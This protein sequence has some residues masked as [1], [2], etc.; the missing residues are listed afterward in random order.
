MTS[1]VELD[2]DHPLKEVTPP[3][4]TQPE[5]FRGSTHDF[6]FESVASITTHIAG[7]QLFVDY[8]QQVKG[9]HNINQGLAPGELAIHQQYKLIKNMEIR[10]SS[11]FTTNQNDSNMEMEVTAE[12]SLYAC[13]VIPDRGDMLVF[14][15]GDG[16][17]CVCEIT[18]S[19]RM[20]IFKETTYKI[21]YQLKSMLDQLS[22]RNLNLKVV[23]TY[24]FDRNFLTNG[25]NPVIQEDDFAILRNIEQFIQ[26][27]GRLYYAQFFSHEFMTLV[28]PSQGTPVYD[29]FLMRFIQYI[30]DTDSAPENRYTR[31]FNIDGD[32]HFST[33]T[34]WDV[35]IEQDKNLLPFISTKY[36]LASARSFARDPQFCSLYHSGMKR[37]VYPGDPRSRYTHMTTVPQKLDIG[38]SIVHAPANM[39]CAGVSTM[40]DPDYDQLIGLDMPA[41]YEA[42]KEGKWDHD[43][44][45]IIDDAREFDFDQNLNTK[46]M[47]EYYYGGT[48]GSAPQEGELAIDNLVLPVMI[49]PYTK[50]NYYLF[51]EFFYC[52]EKLID[53]DQISILEKMVM[54]MLNKQSVGIDD[55]M[56]AIKQFRGWDALEKFYY[57]PVL[58]L[59]AKYTIHTY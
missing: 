1:I 10:V 58:V 6:K 38:A 37:I 45:G 57:I 48:G 39:N 44:D 22:F 55:L 8:Y 9:E 52:K 54:R 47:P 40:P 49:H 18:R 3:I 28:V 16:M 17:Y 46:D 30:F 25:R 13:G 21:S 56:D 4:K 36:Y 26:E 32:I 50:D 43:S 31:Q 34:I 2:D 5:K 35:L 41:N 11:P 7:R 20:E 15:T 19:Q 29:P 59:L 42:A 24:V 51:S 12:A 53:L 14:S 27:A 23:E 33:K